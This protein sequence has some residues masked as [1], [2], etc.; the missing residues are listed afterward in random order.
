MDFSI[1]NNYAQHI[2]TGTGYHLLETLVNMCLLYLFSLKIKWGFATISNK[3]IKDIIAYNAVLDA[4]MAKYGY[5]LT[6]MLYFPNAFRDLCR[7]EEKQTKKRKLSAL[8][9]LCDIQFPLLSLHVSSQ[10]E[11]PDSMLKKRGGRACFQGDCV[12]GHLFET[13]KSC[14]FV[15]KTD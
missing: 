9:E 8:I 5:I 6:F 13:I 11:Q 1:A 14:S 3:E 10:P 7:R 4:L 12:H 2:K 15:F